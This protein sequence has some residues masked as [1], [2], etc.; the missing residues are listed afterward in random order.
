MTCSYMSHVSQDSIEEKVVE[1]AEL[2]LQMDF[3]VIQQGRLAEKQKVIIPVIERF[4]D[5]RSKQVVES[6]ELA[7]VATMHRTFRSVS[8]H[9]YS[10]A[11]LILVPLMLY[12]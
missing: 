8:C 2:K 10:S 3:A 1:R 5:Q 11:R 4:S 6:F 9:T 12:Q 7:I